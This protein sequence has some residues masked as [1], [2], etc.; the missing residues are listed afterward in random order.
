MEEQS[1]PSRGESQAGDGSS[2]R[3]WGLELSQPARPNAGLF[4]ILLTY[5][6]LLTSAI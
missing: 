4:L 1:G 6:H 3:K 2:D 5:K